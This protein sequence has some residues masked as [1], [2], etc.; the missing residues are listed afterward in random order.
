MQ[1]SNSYLGSL[2]PRAQARIESH[3]GIAVSFV[4]IP[5]PFT[6]D[7][8]GAEVRIHETHESDAALFTLAHL[9]GHTV[10]WNT[11][12]RARLIGGNEPGRYSAAELAE[13]RAYE[14]EASRY[15]LQ[16]LHEAG[17]ADLDGWLSDF[18]AADLAFLAHYYATGERQPVAD[19]WVEGQPLL[20]PLAIPAFQ[21]RRFKFRWEGVVVQ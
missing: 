14:H 21:P 1:P 11:S 20:Q 6:G 18:A 5:P 19:F 12:D 7:L 10:Q 9:F 2:L 15:G 17:I 16:L 8:D 4:A 13:V 3:Y